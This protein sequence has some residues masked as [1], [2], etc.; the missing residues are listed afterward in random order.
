MRQRSPCWLVYSTVQTHRPRPLFKPVSEP[1]NVRIRV[2]NNANSVPSQFRPLRG[3]CLSDLFRE[4]WRYDQ[5]ASSCAADLPEDRNIGLA[6]DMKRRMLSHRQHPCRQQS[7][8]RKARSCR[9]SV[10]R[11]NSRACCS[12]LTCA[13][14]I[15]FR[16]EEKIRCRPIGGT[17]IGKSFNCVAVS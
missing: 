13:L 3:D 15:V 12:Q 4:A 1:A 8:P 17:T 9:H 7:S 16:L 5:Q 2:K 6:D 11:S 10:R 14:L